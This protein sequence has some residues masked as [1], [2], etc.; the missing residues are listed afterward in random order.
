MN[1]QRSFHPSGAG[2]RKGRFEEEAVVEG[3]TGPWRPAAPAH[4]RASSFH[5]GAAIGVAL[6]LLSTSLARTQTEGLDANPYRSRARQLSPSSRGT[7]IIISEIMY[8]PLEPGGMEALEYI[9]L[10]NT[11]P[12]AED[13]GGYRI[14]GAVDFTFPAGARLSG[15]SF[16][17]VAREPEALRQASGITNVAGPFTGSLPN[18]GGQVQLRNRTGALLLEIGYE[19][20]M[21]WPAAA[22]GAGHSLQLARP[23][24]GEGAVGAW[25]ASAFRGGSPGRDDPEI[26]DPL[27]SV[28]VNE[29]LAQSEFPQTDFIELHNRSAQTVDLSGCRLSDRADTDKF[30][31]PAGALLAPGGCAVFS[32]ADLGFS[33]SSQGEA[34][35]LVRSDGARVIDAVRFGAQP[36]G[37]S[38]GRWPDGAGGIRELAQPTPGTPN[39][40][41]A[42]HDIVINEIMYHPISGRAEDEY[43]ELHNRGAHAV[44]V[45]HWRFVDGID[46]MIPPGTVVP[47]GGYLVVARD[48]ASLL[49]RCR[50]LDAA[51]TVGNYEGNLSDRG[52]RLA[53]ARPSDPQLPFQDFVVVDEVAYSDGWGRW[54]DGGGSSL[55]LIDARA[56]N[57]LGPNWQ[58]SDETAKAPWIDIEHT[59]VIDNQA[60]T[61]EELQIFCPQ[62]GEC[63]LDNIELIKAGQPFNRVRNSDFE[64]GVGGWELLGSH[65]RS[66]LEAGEGYASSQSLHVRASSQGRST[67]SVYRITY[68]RIS[69]PISPP[70]AG[71]TFTIRAKGRWIAG[72]PYIVIGIKGHP[73]EAVGALEV[74]GNL[75]SPGQPNSRRVANA[76]PAISDVQHMPVLPAASQNVIVSARVHD[77]DGVAAVALQWRIDGAT[78]AVT[79]A[80]MTDPDGDGVYAGILP[81][82]AAGQIAAFAVEAID[83]AGAPAASRFPGPPPAGAPALECL[84]RFG[85][86]LSPGVFGTY[87]LWVS[88]TNVARWRA[89]QTRSDEPVDTTFTYDDYRTVYN[90]AVAYRGNWRS[91]TDYRNAAYMVEFPKTQRVLG[92]TE[93][94]IDFISL[95]GDNGTKQQEKH[96]YWMARQVDLASIA[97]RYVHVSV[98][99]SALFRYDSLSPSRTLCASWYGDEDP[100]VYEQL[101]PHEPFGDYTSADGSK[102]QA[103]YRYCMRKKMTT[104]PDDDFS[105]LFRIVDALK[106]PA[107]DLYVARV[108]A[109]ADIRSWAGYWVIN[110]MCG[111]WDHYTSPGYP[112]NMYTYIPPYERSRL[113]ANDTDGAFGTVYTLF[114]SAGYMPGIMFA[115]PEFRRVYWRLAHDMVQGPMSPAASDVRLRDWHKVFS[116]HGI[117]AVPPTDMIAWIAAR[118][119]EFMR[120][121]APVTNLAFEASTPN[122]VTSATP[123]T[124]TGKAPIS[125]TTIQVNGQPH[126]IQWVNDTTW[127]IRVGLT[128]GAYRIVFHALNA[129]GAVV[130]SDM[131]MAT[132]TGPGVSLEGKLA[133][134][135]IMHHPAAPSSSFVE[136]HN[137]SPTET[138]PLGGLHVDGIDATIGYGRFIAPGGYAVIASSLPG[139]QSTYGNAEVVVGEFAGQLDHRGETLRLLMPQGASP[140][141]LDQVTYDDGPP[142]PAAADGT[143]AS[144]QVVDPS[145]DNDR[146]GN[147]S[148]I[149]PGGSLPLATPGRSNN[150]AAPL[151]AFPLLWINEVM[152]ANPGMHA[153]NT[154]EFDPWIELFNAGAS[155]LDLSGCYLTSDPLDLPQWAFPPGWT[156]QPGQRL[157]VWADGQPEQTDSSNLHAGFRLDSGG[158]GAVVLS[159]QHLDRAVPLDA[160]AYADIPAGSS[161]GSY[162]EGDPHARQVFHSP[163]PALPNNAAWPPVLVRIN[164]WMPGNSLTLADPADGDFDDWFELYNGGASPADL[165]N[166][167]LTDDLDNPAKYT[168]PPGTII[169]AG[170]FLLIWADEEDD[171]NA[172]GG[173][174]HASF[175]LAA[176]GEQLGLFAPDG[177]RVDGL[178]YGPQTDDVSLGRFPDGADLPFYEMSPPTPRGP[179]ALAGGNRPPIFEPVPEQAVAEA[180][181]L[182][183]RVRAADPDDGQAVRYSFGAGAPAGATLNEIT[184]EFRWTPGEPDGPA[185]L[186]FFIQ[187]ADSGTP[188]GV[189]TVR[190]TVQ[191]AEV[192]QAPTL[193]PIADCALREGQ[194][195][196]LQARA[197]DAD[198]PPQNLRFALATGAPPGLSID[199]VTGWILW[200]VDPDQG[201]STH[202]ITVRVTDDG[203]PPQSDEQ[204]FR[205]VVE[206]QPHAV[207]NEIMYRPKTNRTEFI[208]LLNNS[209]ATAA[210]LAGVRLAAE[211]LAF[212]FPAGSALAPGGFGLVVQDRAAFEAAYGAGLPIFG[213]WAGHLAATG[214]T[215]RLTRAAPNQQ[216]EIL[217]EVR[218][219]AEPPWPEAANGQGGSLQLIDAR[220]DNARVGNWAAAASNSLNLSRQLL[221]MT[222]QWRYDLSGKDLGAGWREPAYD[223]GA[224][225]SGRA[226]LYVEDAAL[227]AP[228]NTPLAIGPMT[229]YFRTAFFYDGPAAGL[230]LQANTIVDDAAVIFINGSEWRRV[231]FN[232]ATEVAFITPAD[233][234]VG[235]AALEGPMIVERNVLRHGTNVVAV[236]VHQNNSGSTDVV[237]GM[238]LEVE[239]TAEPA[240]PGRANSLARVL[241]PF[242]PLYINEALAA[243]ATGPLDNAGEREPWIELANAGPLPASLEGWYMTDSLADLTRW[244]FPAGFRI[245]GMEFRLLWADGQP[246]ETTD[247]DVHT[248][249][250]LENGGLLAL[251]RTQAGA[252]AVVDYLRLPTLLADTSYGLPSD[253]WSLAQSVLDRPTPGERN[254]FLPTPEIVNPQLGSA[255]N[256]SFEWRA[257]PGATYRVLG[258]PAL[259]AESWVTLAE[260]VAQAETMRYAEPL[261]S[262]MRYYRVLIP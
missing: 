34:I 166:Y 179:N 195:L 125:V 167:T 117:A 177:S 230:R 216:S 3:Q 37:A 196:A 45:G 197:L 165:A 137:L 36:G 101:Y 16:V 215:I 163:T 84:V 175:K 67:I 258:A 220:Q 152:P 186:S 61:M 60:G 18:S 158:S 190:V 207:V 54:T 262:P 155:A 170:G 185:S 248:G 82:Q 178:S 66:G 191:V 194:T 17:V 25:S 114:P 14:S 46:F 55:E 99:G 70:A 40:E 123:L 10:F 27:D 110:R 6:A 43:V 160:I 213:E 187:A 78:G 108:S 205:I 130:G 252:P 150:V 11:E 188:A 202:S 119:A 52:E 69:I 242:P 59:G 48:R 42:L 115:K 126:A 32:E 250:R 192:N 73:L 85:D 86:A 72:W 229:F 22:D 193:F 109:L 254:R 235:N 100:H 31:I 232:D 176:G 7:P 120:E 49:E 8:H 140:I 92:D 241:P 143:G 74:P 111:N 171:Q 116:D 94:A 223:D 57:A 62:G 47:A 246:A 95:N 50:Q 181:L 38:S 238:D 26:A 71:E 39:A 154:G 41:P 219:T 214:D 149:E 104:V 53:L 161:Y 224:W 169:P 77:P 162:P 133:F 256:V 204:S 221:T 106:S 210:D 218:F 44:D 4:R 211:H 227:P 253:G 142:W 148:A 102:K 51:S 245:E 134:S 56:D 239:S 261:G 257:V 233:R 203:P 112:H 122:T 79:A 91:F 19:D 127:Q 24:Y 105:P 260:S 58:G 243:N 173:D 157:L 98:N 206:L 247:A 212:A 139:Y 103:K 81:G 174:L 12:V 118:R 255:G 251:V 90:S 144:L 1:Q 208:E 151:P 147:W 68:D 183:F 97:M 234:L 33:L 124:V 180:S 87:R 164:E 153:D 135:E 237:W 141:V 249:F 228:K 145:R 65:E 184:G 75:G 182:S 240:T 201:A 15:R 20:Q 159:W 96:A 156:I 244:P 172:P 138:L 121:L 217:D 113:H 76:G 9:E 189:G 132:Y 231:G 198:L 13:L 63:L 199:P 64:Y 146:V 136:I 5:L 107:D 209:S 168:I 88:S 30:I 226:L 80:S 93:V 128:S 29:F 129:Q 259:A 225:P 89:R 23:D 83:A 236:E 131:L 35:F 21:P 222:N 200:P 28:A 2:P